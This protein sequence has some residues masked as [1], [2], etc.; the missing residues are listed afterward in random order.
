MGPATASKKYNILMLAP[1][2]FFADYGCHVRILEEAVVLRELGH[3]VTILAYPNGRDIWEIP[4][5]RSWGVPFNARIEV[6]SSRHKIYLDILMGIKALF[7]TLKH[8][9]DIIHGHLHEGSLIGW[10]LSKITGAPLVFDFQGSLTSEMLDHKFISQDGA[11]HKLFHWLEKK[12]DHMG[13]AIFTSSNHGAQVLTHDYGVPVGRVH[14]TPDCVNPHTFDPG[15]YSA[16]EISATKHQLNLPDDKTMLVYVGL[17][18]QYQGVDFMLQ[19]LQKLSL[20]RD[21][22]HLLLMGFPAVEKYRQMAR[23]LGVAERVTFT[24]K[25]PYEALA[26][27]LAVGNIA[28]A[29][30]LSNTEGNGKILNYASMALP[31]VAFKTPVSREYLGGHGIYAKDFTAPALADALD[32]ALNYSAQARKVMGNTLRHRIQQHYTWRPVGEQIELVYR[33]VLDGHPQPARA[34]KQIVS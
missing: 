12:I 10:I 18:T 13:R 8:K 3:H 32:I 6:G 15:Q 14:P 28:I 23:G 22:F 5:V 34:A 29:P 26:R 17:L 2:M 31:I 33:A 1:T 20:K 4:V 24:G 7:Y 25:V 11:A 16:T 27:Y 19:A 30:K 9:P 21:D